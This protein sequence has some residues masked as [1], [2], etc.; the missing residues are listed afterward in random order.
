MIKWYRL[1]KVL[2]FAMA[3]ADRMWMSR[4]MRANGFKRRGILARL[5]REFV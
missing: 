4:R 2:A 1:L 5:F 3:V